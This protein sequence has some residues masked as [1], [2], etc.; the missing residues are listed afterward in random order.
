MAPIDILPQDVLLNIFTLLATIDDD[1]A[2]REKRKLIHYAS[3]IFDA[4]T[5]LCQSRWNSHVCQFWRATILQAPSIWARIINIPYLSQINSEWRNAVLLRTGRAPLIIK[6]ELNLQHSSIP[7]Q[8]MAN[9]ILLSILKEDMIRIKSLDVTIRY[10]TAAMASKA[11]KLFQ[12][13]APILEIFKLQY[14]SWNHSETFINMA[15][16]F[17]NQAPS[18]RE[19]ECT[20]F[21]QFP[22]DTS[23]MS[24]LR[25]LRIDFTRL[26]VN[27]G[28]TLRINR[29]AL[30]RALAQMQSLHTLE[31]AF[32]PDLLRSSGKSV[33]LEGLRLPDSLK[34]ISLEADFDACLDILRYAPHSTPTFHL[35]LKCFSDHDLPKPFGTIPSQHATEMQRIIILYLRGYLAV[36]PIN[37]LSVTIGVNGILLIG[38]LPNPDTNKNTG[39]RL[40][41]PF[42]SHQDLSSFLKDLSTLRIDAIRI[43]EINNTFMPDVPELFDHFPAIASALTGVETLRASPSFISTLNNIP[44]TLD[45]SYFP[46]LREIHAGNHDPRAIPDDIIDFLHCRTYNAKNIETV[47]LLECDDLLA[48][49]FLKLFGGFRGLTIKWKT[50]Q[51]CERIYV[52]GDHGGTWLSHSQGA[53]LT[54][55]PRTLKVAK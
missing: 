37:H 35:H 40:P 32:F 55:K 8:E 47:D 54:R 22:L 19:F 6:A 26:K 9:S 41:I 25:V 50:W 51:S 17:A 1:P 10:N 20:S 39:F 31:A 29:A 27:Y 52:V 53:R 14:S 46:R 45:A 2:W 3:D 7:R 13:P 24:Q 23:W 30:L 11:S 38:R 12:Q 49:Q 33:G 44:T 48:N 36:N 34:S 5:A 43:F 18:L 42:N 16:L 21:P 4:G 15:D 28:R